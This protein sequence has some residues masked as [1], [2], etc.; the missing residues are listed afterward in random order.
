M[1]LKLSVVCLFLLY[2]ISC[3][4]K[5]VVKPDTEKSANSA[6]Y[7][8]GIAIRNNTNIRSNASTGGNI[9]DTI[10]DGDPVQVLQ[11]KNGW[12]KIITSKKTE[13][14]IR[15]DF[16][17]TRSLSY[18]VKSTD[19]E[20]ST[21]KKLNIEMYI[22]EHNPYAVIYMVLPDIYYTD[23]TRA[24]DVVKKI[25]AEYQQ[26]V[27]PGHVEIRILKQDKKTVFTKVSLNKKG[28]VNLK[29][30]FLK[31]GRLYSFKL[32]D[33]KAIKIK[34][35]IP[36][37]LSDDDLYDMGSQISANY[38]DDIRKIE[39]YF[40]IDNPEGIKFI[41]S[42]NYTPSDSH[43]CRFYYLEDSNGQD[44]KSNYCN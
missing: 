18:S 36:A 24:E 38:G 23:K 5:K 25:G 14:W 11:N 7:F 8:N 31:T 37:G 2:I 30:P 3:T 22:D 29:A 1:I 9:V 44:Y 41:S 34:V 39:I 10:N 19:F 33:G 17:G 21:L 13:G 6:V 4:S 27:Y 32:I 15:S 16:I 28:A 43:V 40:I 26:K 12:Y 35:L 20:D 42:R